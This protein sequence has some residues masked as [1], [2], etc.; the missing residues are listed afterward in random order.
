[1]RLATAVGLLIGAAAAWLGGLI[2][3][4]T[5]PTSAVPARV[6]CALGA[7]LA[8]I[9]LAANAAP[10]DGPA[11]LSIRGGTFRVRPRARSRAFS[12]AV[13]LLALLTA[14]LLAEPTSSF[15]VALALGPLGWAVLATAGAAGAIHL[16]ALVTG[17]P[18]LSITPDA[19]HVVT[20]IRRRVVPWAA[21][22]PGTP[23]V[24][25]HG[26][27]LLG[28]TIDRP[29]LVRGG[30]E[31]V[32]L[33]VRHLDVDPDFLVEA[34]RHYV[35]HPCDRQGIGTEAGRRDLY[36]ELESTRAQL[37]GDPRGLDDDRGRGRVPPPGQVRPLRPA[38][39]GAARLA[40]H[41]GEPVGGRDLG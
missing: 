28:L 29:D 41:S 32:W 25:P 15:R 26:D 19:V 22:R 36:A 11:R 3:H 8:A 2:A 10:A 12:V 6:I 20:A 9:A 14:G 34:L 4:L 31:R 21:V 23:S 18:T 37:P 5:V 38:A 24:N 30:P 16:N 13:I 17:R 33:P 35:D 39:D 1:M 7:L 27:W 40:D